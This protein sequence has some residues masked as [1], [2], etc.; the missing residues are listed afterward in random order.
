MALVGMLVVVLLAAGRR[1]PWRAW[2]PLGLGWL[3]FCTWPVTYW[4][5]MVMD[6]ISVDDFDSSQLPAS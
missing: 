3:G 4:P 5:V 1:W 2:F 6:T